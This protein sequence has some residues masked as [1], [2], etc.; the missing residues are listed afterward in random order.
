MLDR[1]RTVRSLA[2]RP[3]GLRY[4]ILKESFFTFFDSSFPFLHCHMCLSCFLFEIL[5]TIFCFRFIALS[6]VPHS[7]GLNISFFTLLYP[8]T[9]SDVSYAFMFYAFQ[10]FPVMCTSLR[11]SH[12]FLFYDSHSYPVLC[13]LIKHITFF[14]FTFAILILSCSL[15]Q[16]LTTLVRHSYLFLFYI[17][18]CNIFS[19]HQ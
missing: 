7:V 16:I 19:L 2:K 12:P 5:D 18:H 11:R 14:S 6:C 1:T 17:F 10:Y 15:Y 4:F 3:S 8:T 13:N 9:I